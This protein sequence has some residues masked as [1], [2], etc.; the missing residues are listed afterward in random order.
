MLCS[1]ISNLKLVTASVW[2]KASN[3]KDRQAQPRFLELKSKHRE[4]VQ[5]LLDVLV[6]Q[7]T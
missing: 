1:L 3:C 7:D 4:K 6:R 5:C 2:R